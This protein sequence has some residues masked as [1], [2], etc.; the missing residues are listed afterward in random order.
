MKWVLAA[1]VCIAALAS[2]DRAMFKSA[3]VNALK[4]AAAE[5][6]AYYR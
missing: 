1:A 2:I 5:S 4:S 3:Y 6:A